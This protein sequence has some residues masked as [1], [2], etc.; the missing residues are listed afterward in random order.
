MDSSQTNMALAAPAWPPPGPAERRSLRPNHLTQ[1]APDTEP[2]RLRAAGPRG[3]SPPPA[4]QRRWQERPEKEGDRP[5]SHS[6]TVHLFTCLEIWC[7]WRHTDS[8]LLIN[9]D[10]HIVDLQCFKCIA[11]W[12]RYTHI[13]FQI[14]SL[15]RL[16]Q[17]L[18]ILPCA[19]QQILAGYLFYL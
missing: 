11:K 15:Y 17:M 18:S 10:W 19:M 1:E 9:F 13:S 16:L 14:V 5:R 4:S 7:Y 6:K 3:Q 12:F 2:H 8:F